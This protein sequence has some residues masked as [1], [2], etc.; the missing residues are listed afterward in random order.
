MCPLSV[1]NSPGATQTNGAAGG[2]A[3]AGH[4]ALSTSRGPAGGRHGSLVCADGALSCCLRSSDGHAAAGGAA[5]APA[6]SGFRHHLVGSSSCRSD[7]LIS[8]VRQR[9]CPGNRP[10]AHPSPKERR[11]SRQSPAGNRSPKHNWFYQTATGTASPRSINPSPTRTPAAKV[12]TPNAPNRKI[13]SKRKVQTSSRG[14]GKTTGEKPR[15]RLSPISPRS[16]QV[17]PLLAR[18]GIFWDGPRGCAVH[19]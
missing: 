5:C 19:S 4:Q 11:G 16:G 2:A 17:I 14:A 9:N 3:T 6:C 18:I 13:P 10:T 7:L 8:S 15:P 12:A 1:A